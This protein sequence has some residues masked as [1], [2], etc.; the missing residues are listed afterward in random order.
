[1]FK[2]NLFE[3]QETNEQYF[4]KPSSK[5][6]NIQIKLFFNFRGIKEYNY[7]FQEFINVLKTLNNSLL[8]DTIKISDKLNKSSKGK[9]KKTELDVTYINKI[10]KPFGT[11]VSS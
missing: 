3:Y 11:V 6:P 1:M 2:K 4:F 5:F 9:I 7:R 10:D 8:L